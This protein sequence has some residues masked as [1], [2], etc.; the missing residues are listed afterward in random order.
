MGTM[1]TNDLVEQS[2]FELLPHQIEKFNK[3]GFGNA[4]GT[5]HAKKNNDFDRKELG[6]TKH[7]NDAFHSQAK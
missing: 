5:L 1:A 6:I 7:A 2:L 4:E 3:I